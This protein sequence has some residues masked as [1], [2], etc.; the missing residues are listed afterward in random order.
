MASKQ[1]RITSKQGGEKGFHT[2]IQQFTFVFANFTTDVRI[3]IQAVRHNL[4]SGDG[5]H[6]SVMAHPPYMLGE[7]LQ[8]P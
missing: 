1:R 3:D 4:F 2:A 7:D 6:A 5:E 8:E